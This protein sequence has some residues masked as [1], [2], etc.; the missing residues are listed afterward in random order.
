MFVIL[1]L[2]SCYYGDDST[3]TTPAPAGSV[4]FRSDV[5]PIFS[6]P[7]NSAVA[8]T[9]VGCHVGSTPQGGLDLA[10]SDSDEATLYSSV[11]GEINTGSPATSLLLTKATATVSHGGGA[12][13]TVGSTDYNTILQ[14]ITDG[15]ANN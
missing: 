7:Q 10:L 14:W 13:M 11:Q 1:G 5:I 15:A 12:V 2:N 8:C 9:N 3:G 4:S 6:K